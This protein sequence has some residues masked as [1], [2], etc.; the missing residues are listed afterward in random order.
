MR[1]LYGSTSWRR[2]LALVLVFVMM[3]STMGTSGYSVFADDLTET[4]E[5]VTVTEPEANVPEVTEDIQGPSPGEE[6]VTEPVEPA[7]ED[8]EPVEAVE[9]AAE[10]K[11]AEEPTE[12]VEE[13]EE[14]EEPS[15]ENA[16]PVEPTEEAIE[17]EEVEEPVEPVE[18]AEGGEEAV[19]EDSSE[20]T[21]VE[22]AS[23]IVAEDDGSACEAPE[24]VAEPS[25][26]S[27]T[28]QL[29][30]D[31]LA[32]EGD[33]ALEELSEEELLEE[34]LLE[35]PEVFFTDTMTKELERVIVTAIPS[36][37]AFREKVNMSVVPIPDK[38]RMY[39]EAEAALAESGVNY[40]GMLAYDISFRN[41]AGDLVEPE[42]S[43]SITMEITDKALAAVDSDNMDVE[44]LVMTHIGSEATEAVADVAD[45]TDGSVTVSMSDDVVDGIAAEFVV[46]SF[47]TFVLTWTNNGEEESATIHWGTYDGN[48]FKEFDSI[49]TADA[50]ASSIDLAVII[51]GYYFTGAMYKTPETPDGV[52]LG[53]SVIRKG[54]D[55][56]WLV[57]TVLYDDDG[58]VTNKNETVAIVDG[59]DIYVYYAAKEGGG[60]YTPPGP[61]PA[62]LDSI[63]PETQKQV[64]ANG[65]G[66]YTIRL[67]VTGHATEDVKIGANVIVMLDM[68]R[69]MQENDMNGRRIAAAKSALLSLI[70]ALNPG[71]DAEHPELNLVNFTLAT[72][73]NTMSTN[74]VRT[75]TQNRAQMES[76]VRNLSNSPNAM[77]TNWQGGLQGAETLAEAANNDSE[78]KKNPTY[79]IFVTDGAPNCWQGHDSSNTGNDLDPRA[80]PYAQTAANSLAGD[81]ILYGVFCGPAGG[82]D[83]LSNL[84][85]EAQGA[86]TINGTSAADLQA[87][88]SQIA[89]HIVAGMAAANVTVD[90]GIPSLSNVSA[91]V[92]AGEAGG[93]KYYITPAG[94]EETEWKVKALGDDDPG[95]PGATYDKSNGVTWDLGAVGELQEGWVYS[96]EFTVWPSQEAYD[97]IADLNNG[98]KTMTGDELKAAGIGKRADGTYYLLTNTH[99][100]TTFSD[101]S[102]QVYD[103]VEEDVASKAME[104]PTETIGVQ[105]IWNNKLDKQKPPAEVKL[106]LT[107]DGDNYLFGNNAI[108]V[109]AGNNWAVDDIYISLGQIRTTADGYEILETG[110]DYEI[111][112][113]EGDNDYRWELTSEV[114]HPMVIDGSATMLIK[115]EKATGTEGTNYYVIGGTKYKVAVAGDN[116]LRGWNDRRSWLQIEKNVT[117]EGAPEDA[118]FE[119]TVKIND[120]N[121]EDVWY[122]AYGPDGIIKDLET[123]G[124]AET[125]DT[126]YYYDSSGTAITVKLQA[127]WTLRFLNLPSG[128]TYTVEETGFPDGFAFV[129]AED[130]QV[131]DADEGVE[132]AEPSRPT[133]TGKKAEGTI[134]VPNVEF[135][136]DYTNK[137]EE[138]SVTVTKTWADG[139]NQDNLRPDALPLT[140]NGL[141]AGTTAPSPTITKNGNNWTYTWSDLPKYIDGEEVSYT[142]SEDDVPEGYKVTGSPANPNATITNSHTPA[143]TTVSITKNWSDEDDQDGLRPTAAEFAAKVHL[144]AG[145]TIVEDAAATVTDNGDGTY[146]VTYS[147]LPKM[148]AGTEISYTVKEDAING[149]TTQNDTAANGGT[150][151]NSHTPATIAVSITKSWND[152]NDHDGLRPTAAEFAEKVHLY[153]G[154]AIVEDAA[155]TVT[156]NGDGTYTVTYSDLPKMAAGTEISYT[157]KEDTINGYTTQSD[158]AANGGTIT[159]SHIPATTSVSITKSWSDADDQ[160]GLR[161]TATEFAAKVHLY[162]GETI[163]EDAAATVTDNGDG[164][165][166]VTYSNLPKMAAGTEISYTVKEDAIN[167]YTTQNDTAANG[168]TI[169]NSHTPA[170]TS[171]S[172]TKSWNDANNQDGNRPDTLNVRLLANGKEIRS[173]TLTA[174]EKWTAT[175]DKLPVKEDGKTI[176]YTWEE[177][178]PSGYSLSTKTEGT[179]TTLTNSYTPGKTSVN[180]TKTWNDA[181]DQDG[182]RPDSVTINLLADGKVIKTVT[183]G[184]AEQWHWEFTD[185][186]EYSGGEKVKYTVEEVA[187]EGY[188]TEVN[189]YNITNTHEV[190][191]INVTAT[192]TWS[193]YDNQYNTR[194]QSITVQLYADDKVSG[195]PVTITAAEDGT[196]TYTWSELDR[197]AGGK[198]ITYTVDELEVPN[199]YTRNIGTPVRL[200]DGSV[201]VAITNTYTRSESPSRPPKPPVEEPDEPI[202]DPDIPLAPIE[203]DPDEEIPEDDTPLAPYEEEP[204]EEISEEPTPFSPFTGDDRHTAVWGFVSLLS[205]AGIVVV[206]RKRREE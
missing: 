92:T 181:N 187:V 135:Y 22:E 202:E 9:E 122:S 8:E 140:L 204:D 190:E 189:G 185:L 36:E 110:H 196:W 37:G 147:N 116:M 39:L 153:A 64:N 150:I 61:A 131:N 43:V 78:L 183:V 133:I 84:V 115:D 175:V 177:D 174:A 97:T 158:T 11:E 95:A 25:V 98:I 152:A 155:A 52:V 93:F 35:E 171:V 86:G 157:V 105:K 102:G 191:K 100:N 15:E 83:N 7:A 48:D 45:E 13:A 151:T 205:L 111:V 72:F 192:K 18:E 33:A 138:T 20:P 180:G 54:T 57:E 109:S 188:K 27:D 113:L 176:S 206:A 67:D 130:R 145:E 103:V 107:K 46:D 76:A 156:D 29:I 143:T 149:Y 69:S 41:E 162:A 199:I 164:T 90:D 203:E 139:N 6:K 55:G 168:G 12:A 42:A 34:E 141:P 170:T 178:L 101:P 104:L 4:G 127:G 108:K 68:T 129:E 126:G 79:V 74:T 169:T 194:P 123:S 1:T 32:Q 3:V 16:E 198:E 96:V 119:F 14:A 106:T 47:S 125:G 26:I 197:Y 128:T 23:Q 51:D 134:N 114:Y 120:A 166:T 136:V 148:A 172:I 163:V 137:Y 121:K 81:A 186:D 99:L 167:G 19:T 40:D 89:S 193:D 31:A 5:E 10:V 49:T 63:A 30:M 91:N 59:S 94:G 195:D 159:N 44:S 165:Y 117:G 88:F 50:N 56:K 62:T 80:L 201:T 146:T 75:W 132:Q 154:G 2:V 173:I 124:T 70:D 82:F 53:D 77:G 182:I 28:A 179:V 142:V 85:T 144:Y 65:D 184:E 24:A 161:P 200:E 17:D 21:L 160:D 112:E 73:G 60:G 66:T 118:L 87:A 71:Y 38:S 58:N